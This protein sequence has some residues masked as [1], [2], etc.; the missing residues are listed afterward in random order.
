MM[1]P[2]QKKVILV[3][4]ETSRNNPDLIYGIYLTAAK[5]AQYRLVDEN[6]REKEEAKNETAKKIATPRLYLQQKN[7]T[8]F[9]NAK[10]P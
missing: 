2:Q 1:T 4:G 7:L 3:Y 5:V 10:T 6:R 9:R 8:L